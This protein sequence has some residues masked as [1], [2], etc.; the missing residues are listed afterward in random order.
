MHDAV[1]PQACG[2]QRPDAEDKRLRIN[3]V[4]YYTFAELKRALLAAA[5]SDAAR[6]QIET[7]LP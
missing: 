4:R 2:A 5:E 3:R 7:L 6:K 1:G